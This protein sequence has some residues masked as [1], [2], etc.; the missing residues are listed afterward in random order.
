MYESVSPVVEIRTY[1]F[2]GLHEIIFSRTSRQFEDLHVYEYMFMNSGFAQEVGYMF[3][4]L[5]KNFSNPVL[6]IHVNKLNKFYL[7]S[8]KKNCILL[9]VVLISDRDISFKFTFVSEQTLT[10]FI[11]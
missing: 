6:Q 11:M 4:S 9:H 7:H 1:D 5:L 2:I 10:Y 3:M 8:K